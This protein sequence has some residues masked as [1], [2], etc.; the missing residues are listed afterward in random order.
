MKVVIDR[1]AW[2]LKEELT[3]TQTLSIKEALTIQPRKLGDFPGDDPEPIE[4][5]RETDQHLGVPRQFFLNNAKQKHEIIYNYSERETF[6]EPLEF[7]GQLRT[8]QAAGVAKVVGDF[9]GGELGGIVR[10]APGWGKTVAVCAIIARLSCPTIVVVH[11]EFL[12]NQWKERIQQFLPEASIGL[13]QGDTCDY[14]DRHIVLAM[15][16]SL[17]QRVYPPGLY[18]YPQLFVT[19]EVHRIGAETW[20]PVPAKFSARWRLGVSATPRRKDGA[21]NVFLYHIGNVVFG[22]TE[23]RLKV[24]VKRVWTT[25]KLVKTDKFNPTLA[26]R[27]LVIRFLVNSRQRNASIVDQLVRAVEAGRKPLVLSER[28]QHL[29]MLEEMFTK[30]WLKK[31]PDD[32]KTTGFYV[33]GQKEEQR[34]EAAEAQVI[35]ATSQ[36]ASEGL[37]IPALDT[38]LLTTPLSDV[39][40]A[41]G[42]I[43]RPHPGKKDPIV[44]DFRDDNIKIFRSSADNRDRLYRRVT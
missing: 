25:F 26:P 20:S 43:Q 39:E 30:E 37:D 7:A 28:L 13:V 31:F 14:V 27:T 10:A 11:K 23:Q 19:D 38:L 6:D 8:E 29:H 17:S 2:L 33:G 5:W 44:V 12:M 22:A 16:Q 24:K 9:E 40:Q 3:P 36:F 35:F 4:L 32:P 1:Y 42:R 34:K 15:V 21:D 41:V 18:L